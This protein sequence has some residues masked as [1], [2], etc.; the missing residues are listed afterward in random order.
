[1]QGGVRHGSRSITVSGVYR[2]G[3]IFT[4]EVKPVCPAG[5]KVELL[6]R[7]PLCRQQGNACRNAVAGGVKVAVTVLPLHTI[8]NLRRSQTVG[9]RSGKGRAVL[10]ND[11]NSI[12]A[13]AQL[14]AIQI[15]RNCFQSVRTQCVS[16]QDFKDGAKTGKHAPSVN[17]VVVPAAGREKPPT[18]TKRRVA[19]WCVLPPRIQAVPVFDVVAVLVQHRVPLIALGR[20]AR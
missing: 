8:S 16:V 18:R 4:G 15:K 10:D 12:C 7:H 11:L 13:A 6:G 19:T 3:N 1:M 20:T 5:G 9:R 17:T 2:A 14:A